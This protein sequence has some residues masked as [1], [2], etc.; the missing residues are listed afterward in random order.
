M[1]MDDKEFKE[2]VA[3]TNLMEDPE[4]FAEYSEKV[5]AF[6]KKNGR[7]PTWEEGIAL[8]G[9]RLAAK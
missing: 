9:N 5:E 6:R 1:T 7:P 8:H 4:G 3:S 2:L